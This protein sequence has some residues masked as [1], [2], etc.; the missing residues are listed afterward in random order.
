MSNTPIAEAFVTIRPEPG[1]FAAATEQEIRAGLGD[2]VDVPA[3][4]KVQDP[5]ATR[6][7]IEQAL[8]DIQASVAVNADTTAL[9]PQITG[10]VGDVSAAVPVTADTARLQSE[11][12]SVVSSLPPQQLQFD[13]GNVE[14]AQ[15]EVAV[16]R[17]ELDRINAVSLGQPLRP[18]ALQ[19]EQA[20]TA[21]QRLDV[22][23]AQLSVAGDVAQTFGAIEGQADAAATATDALGAD[24]NDAATAASAIADTANLVRLGMVSTSAATGGVAEATT[25]VE[26]NVAA[27]ADETDVLRSELDEA[28]IAAIGLSNATLD[29]VRGLELSEDEAAQ[30][31]ATTRDLAAAQALFKTEQ[32]K[33]IAGQSRELEALAGQLKENQ[34]L[35]GT[36]E[37]PRQPDVL[38]GMGEPAERAAAHA[39]LAAENRTKDLIAELAA[40]QRKREEVNK[41]TL[42]LTGNTAAERINTQAVREGTRADKEGLGISIRGRR[43]GAIGPFRL[44]GLGVGVGAALF[45]ATRA[46]GEL[47]NAIEV[48]DAK[49]A[50]WDVKLRNFAANTL[51]GDV[52]GAFGAL[53]DNTKEYS[54]AQLRVISQTPELTRVLKEMGQSA[55]LAAGATAAL[56]SITQPRQ[57]LQTALAREERQGDIQGQIKTLKRLRD[58]ALL[59][60]QIAQNVGGEQREVNVALEAIEK[61][62]KT[63]QD[64]LAAIFVAGG[65]AGARIAARIPGAQAAGDLPRVGDLL[66]SQADAI[67]REITRVEQKR[68]DQDETT[69]E[70]KALTARIDANKKALATAVE[71]VVRTATQPFSFRGT[72]ILRLPGEGPSALDQTVQALQAENL[73]LKK[74]RIELQARIN[75]L[76]TEGKNLQALK[77]ELAAVNRAN[78]ANTQA[79]LDEEERHFQA[80]IDQTTGGANLAA[81]QEQAFGTPQGQIRALQAEA[82]QIQALLPILK[83][84][85]PD[86]YKEQL[87]RL[88]A[89][90]SEIKG[91]QDGIT[92][93]QE[94]HETELAA[95]ENEEHQ[96]LLNGIARREQRLLNLI[97]RAEAAGQTGLQLQKRLVAF[98]LRQSKNQQLTVAERQAFRDQFVAASNTLR[99]LN[100][101]IAD[102]E[103]QQVQD[104]IDARED[105]LQDQLTLAKLDERS[106]A[107]DRRRL[108]ALIDFYKRQAHNLDLTVSA[109]RDY[110]IKQR[111]AEKDLRDLNKEGQETA[112]DFSEQAFEFLQ[113]QQGFFSTFGSNV[114][115]AGQFSVGG[116]SITGGGATFGKLAIPEPPTPPSLSDALRLD[117]VPSPF[118]HGRGRGGA[119]D[120][121]ALR[122]RRGGNA[123]F[124]QIETLIQKTTTTNRL[125][126]DI[127]RGVGHPEQKHTRASSHHA[128]ETG[129]D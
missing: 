32:Q 77:D 37:G 83:A 64:A 9:Q 98:Y 89:I 36:F 87:A 53:I 6:T 95:A 46:V 16:L 50:T 63:R 123:T 109:R 90:N 104:E 108:K 41:T 59:A 120:A 49:T 20:T 19:A 85:V 94:R 48:T 58:E 13:L 33:R 69:A 27:A 110:L 24:L 57:F 116:T 2:G 112:K 51:R 40:E 66:Q 56:A 105:L 127:R 15:S 126:G 75:D 125:L 28:T 128:L 101:E 107:D 12:E 97:S 71:G 92:A 17:T 18:V 82:L 96:V 14:Q 22:G 106:K 93:E 80:L 73:D 99:G 121:E 42:A 43:P 111:Q 117:R 74:R 26:A 39:K 1:S 100:K 102:A 72:N 31:L 35:G 25:D 44:A 118:E 124:G 122:E 68:R 67:R 7:E 38:R 129:M 47:A 52:V 29:V 78:E 61:E 45:T 21:V 79:I 114:F 65:P 62:L 11:V 81:L 70:L 88:V 54:V 55:N 10:A 103:K 60:K 113:Q 4:L 86:Q 8:A 30:L 91:L 115:S 3:N 76:K 119:A 84:F 23:L 5:Q 34:L